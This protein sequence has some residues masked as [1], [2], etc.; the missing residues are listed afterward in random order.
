MNIIEKY[1]KNKEEIEN[2]KN[3]LINYGYEWNAKRGWHC[4]CESL[5]SVNLKEEIK[6]LIYNFDIIIKHNIDLEKELGIEC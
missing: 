4:D 5:L 6:E 1:Y 3:K 2:I